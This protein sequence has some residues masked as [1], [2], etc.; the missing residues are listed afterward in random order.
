MV[1]PT[2]K[3]SPPNS[4]IYI[5]GTI[6]GVLD[7]PK[8]ISRTWEEFKTRRKTSSETSA[9]HISYDWFVLA[10]DLLFLMGAIELVQGRLYKAVTT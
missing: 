7:E 6:L 4:L 9:A 2:R 3:L 5:G 8:T 10:L 1:L